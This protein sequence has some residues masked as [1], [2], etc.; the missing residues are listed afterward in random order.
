MRQNR[1]TPASRVKEVKEVKE[2]RRDAAG[3]ATGRWEFRVSLIAGLWLA[4]GITCDG[5][6][7]R[8]RGPR[9]SLLVACESHT[10][11]RTP[12]E[13][14][15]GDIRH[16]SRRLGAQLVQRKTSECPGPGS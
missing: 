3:G 11:Q 5:D 14:C 13:K 10:P 1:T 12:V 15:L 8:R 9:Q 16:L 2:V 6:D 7:V 4:R